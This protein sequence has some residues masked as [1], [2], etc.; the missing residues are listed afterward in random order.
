LLDHVVKRFVSDVGGVS[1][2]RR[3]FLY[4]CYCS[5]LKWR[6]G[7]G[8]RWCFDQE[9]EAAGVVF[10]AAYEDWP[11]CYFFMAIGC[12]R[13]RCGGCVQLMM[14]LKKKGGCLSLMTEG[15]DDAEY[16]VKR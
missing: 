3:K 1:W 12:Y 5:Q 15:V 8:C 2:S 13:R 11:C 9:G 16:G 10:V 7:V 14:H 6:R 4:C